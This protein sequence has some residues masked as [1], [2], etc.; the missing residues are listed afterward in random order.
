MCFGIGQA[1][2]PEQGD[3]ALFGFGAFG[4]AVFERRLD[5]LV[6]QP[7]GRVE[8]R[9]RRLRDITHLVAAQ[10]AEAADAALH[11]VAAVEEDLA[12]GDFHAAAAKT[13]GGKADGGFAGAGFA[14][15]PEYLAAL[16]E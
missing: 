12:A 9:R 15:K 7:V 16:Q 1:K 14:D 4:V 10:F 6:H 13:H 5:H 8:G 11:D 3:G 2:L